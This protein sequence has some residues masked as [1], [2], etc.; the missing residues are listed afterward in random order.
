MVQAALFVL[1]PLCFEQ[2]SNWRQ[3]ENLTTQTVT[4][5]PGTAGVPPQ[6]RSQASGGLRGKGRLIDCSGGEN[7]KM[8]TMIRRPVNV[9]GGGGELET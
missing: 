5:A 9:T 7:V 6:R 8:V 4:A 2:P 3:L 1:F